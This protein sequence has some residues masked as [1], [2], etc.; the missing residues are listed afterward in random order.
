MEYDPKSDSVLEV[1][2]A[3]YKN[4]NKTNPIKSFH[5]GKTKIVLNRSGPLYFISGT[6]DHCEKGQKLEVQVLSAKHSGQVVAHSPAMAPS[7]I[8]HLAPAPAPAPASGT[9]RLKIEELSAPLA[10]IMASFVGFG[11]F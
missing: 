1:T 2:Q 9:Y 11:L 5:D 10:L 4:C 7:T 3:D 8:K 6:N